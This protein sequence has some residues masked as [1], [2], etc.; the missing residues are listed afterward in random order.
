[1]VS[2]VMFAQQA[3][4]T[5]RRVT[6]SAVDLGLPDLATGAVMNAWHTGEGFALRTN[7]G[8]VMVSTDGESWRA[9]VTAPDRAVNEPGAVGA[10]TPEA[11][12]RLVGSRRQPAR[13]YALGQSIWRSDDGGL[14]WRNLTLA[15]S[16]QLLGEGLQDLAVSPEDPD[17]LIA[18][19]S[20]GAWRSVDGGVTWSGLNAALPNLSVRRL[21]A[22]PE[23]GQALRAE[24]NGQDTNG[25]HAVLEWMAGEKTAWRRA[26]P[27][28]TAADPAFQQRLLRQILTERFQMKLTSAVAN[29]EYVYAGTE[30]GRMVVSPDLMST[31]RW[32]PMNLPGAVSAIATDPADGAMAIAVVASAQGSRVWRTL[33]GG[34]VWDDL[35][36]DLPE[37][38]VN[39]VTFDRAAGAIYLATERGLFLTAADLRARGPET[40]WQRVD[41][42]LPAAT[43]N[44]VKL[45]Q[46]ATQLYA[47][48]EGWGVYAA[49]APHRRRDP[50]L[51]SA[52]DQ[53]VRAAAPGALLSVVGAAIQTAEAGGRGIPVLA[54]GGDEAQIQ[55]PFDVSGEQ[56]QLA[57]DARWTLRLALEATSP[58][59]FLDSDGAP[60]LIDAENGLVVD[61]RTP[62]RAGQ[63][64]QMMAAGLGRVQPEWPAGVAAPMTDAP[65]VVAAVRVVLD[66]VRIEP[67]RAT[68]APGYAGLYLVEF[69]VPTLVNAGEAEISLEA[70]GRASNRS[71]V[72]LAP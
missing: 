34:L 42:G 63:R 33:N 45:N 37:G 25:Q 56:L 30:N 19:S 20:A 66:G 27:R 50:R 35:T 38:A 1:L 47:A 10:Q 7:G 60:V 32:A 18:A 54:S 28:L 44:D 53:S 13:V 72:S 61:A 65:R 62:L 40:P 70:G 26:A 59:I 11:G 8:R 39:G 6:N 68:L 48:V 12:A 43:F 49:R 64:L 71:R 22:L 31:W 51:V 17:D 29:G 55:I 14:N 2:A 67:L 3:P 24:I 46:A 4:S 23:G 41:A 57:L 9:A 52:A 21:H 36:G 58:A 15:K 5:W 16:G 69:Q